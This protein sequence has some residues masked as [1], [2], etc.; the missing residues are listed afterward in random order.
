MKLHRASLTFLCIALTTLP[1]VA[2]WSYDNGPINGTTFA[3]TINNGYVV[4]DSFYSGGPTTGF[5]FGA[6][7]YLGDSLTSVDWSI[8]TGVN[9]GTTIGSGTAT[10]MGGAG[11]KLTDQ[12]LFVNPE[13]YLVD[14]ITVTGLNAST[15]GSSTYWFNLQNAMVPTHDPVFWDQN[16]GVG[17]GGTNCPSQAY[18]LGWDG[19]IPSEA[20][21]IS[22]STGTPEPSGIMLFGSGL[23]GLAGVL[24]RKLH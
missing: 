7:E 9:G 16:S 12:P 22:G 15:A 13:G 23:L 20:F 14:L 11:G 6:W 24:R 4:S 1:A 2:Q 21:S 19:M 8:T 18:Q 3:W 10:T 5:T 17:C